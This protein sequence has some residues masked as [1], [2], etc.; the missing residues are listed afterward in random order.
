SSTLGRI[1]ATNSTAA[2]AFDNPADAN[3]IL[4]AFKAE[5][6]VVA[7]GLYSK[8]RKL[9]SHYPQE[10]PATAFPAIPESDGYRFDGSNLVGVQSV[11][12][13]GQRLGTLYV[14]WDLKVAYAR[15]LFYGASIILIMTICLLAAAYMLSRTLK[16]QVTEPILALAQTA[17]VVSD[18]Q[19]YSVRAQKMGD[20]EIGFLSDVFNNMLAR[21]EEQNTEREQTQVRRQAELNRMQ[22]LER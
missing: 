10:L 20:G 2:L 15:F 3:E 14:R 1:V 19:D 17:K 18:R 7:A 8:Q 5:P 9:F 6:S 16:R 11:V 21:I 13:G 22:L 4:S 12:Q